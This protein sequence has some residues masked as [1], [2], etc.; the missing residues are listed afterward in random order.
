MNKSTLSTITALSFGISAVLFTSS[1]FVVDPSK[2]VRRRWIAV[3]FSAVGYG[4]IQLA[5]KA[6]A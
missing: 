6:K 3:G 5:K 1:F 2:A 4:T